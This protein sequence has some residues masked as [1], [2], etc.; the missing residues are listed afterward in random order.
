MARPGIRRNLISEERT[1]TGKAM[2][3]VAFR[4]LRRHNLFA[5]RNFWC[6]LGCATNACRN[7]IEENPGKYKG[8]VYYHKQDSE[9]LRDHGYCYV[10]F[11]ASN[12]KDK[13]TVKLGRLVVDTFEKRGLVVDWPGTADERIRVAIP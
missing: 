13:D 1:R 10:A 6:C 8:V 4:D 3:A 5:K 2:L 9:Q 11:C 12:N 7:E